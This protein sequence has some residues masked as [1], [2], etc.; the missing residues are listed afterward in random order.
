[1]TR[2]HGFTLSEMLLTILIVGI[3]AAVTLP[4]VQK[5]HPDK[6]EAMRRKSYY[7]LENTVSQ[8]YTDDTMYRKKVDGSDPGFQNTETIKLNGKTYEGRTKFCEL[9]ANSLNKRV[10]T[11]TNCTPNAK[12][13]T[14]SDNVDWYLPVTDFTEGY[15]A[16]TFDVNG[17]AD[18]NC[19]RGAQCK[20]PDRFTY[21]ILS[22]G[23]ITEKQPT[24]NKTTYCIR[25]AITG[26]G[27][28]S[29]SSE[30]CGLS[31]GTYILT[32]T[33]KTGWLSDWSNNEKRIK[34]K[35][36]DASTRVTFTESPKACITLNV[37]CESGLPNTCGSYTI[38]NGTFTQSGN[39]LSACN[40]YA[41]DYMLTVTP[42]TTHTT[43]WQTQTVSLNGTDQTLSVNLNEKKYCATL[44]V[45]CPDGGA[46]V[47]GSYTIT[48]NGTTYG[49]DTSATLAKTCALRNGNYT[50]TVNPTAA[51]KT[52]TPTQSI[53]IA[54]G[55]W[56]GNAE[57]QKAIKNCKTDGYFE[58]NGK[59][60]SCIFTS[61]DGMY[62]CTYVTKNFPS[63]GIKKCQNALD[64]WANA[65]RKCGGVNKLP[66]VQDLNKIYSLI[67][68][69]NINK[70]KWDIIGGSGGYT[71]FGFISGEELDDGSVM[72]VN[73][74]DGQTTAKKERFMPV[75]TFCVLE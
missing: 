58:A 50:L 35:D 39:T 31:N 24:I 46:N 12:T 69:E 45:S 55:D 3:L 61:D 48:G 68:D 10:N 64:T 7:I 28:V 43:S 16:I 9:Y 57:F 66:T 6:L 13:F 19:E 2:S 32:A 40:L 72:I 65:V 14:T 26:H 42:L 59:K 11:T 17:K 34:I 70:F 8:I 44:N 22:N 60:F 33:P 20:K 30:Y 36:K 53:R 4:T 74:Y 41:N 5:A 71:V 67:Y 54:N 75:D 25:T 38:T 73:K 21:Y 47:C 29:P 15:A 52:T 56:D 63:Y 62:A 51:Y 49:M 18:P 37:N 27:T 23:T 1:M